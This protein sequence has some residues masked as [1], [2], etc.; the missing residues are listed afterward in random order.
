MTVIS[1][2]QLVSTTYCLQHIVTHTLSRHKFLLLGLDLAL[3]LCTV[4]KEERIDI[5]TPYTANL[6]KLRG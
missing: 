2:R 5:L 1:Y 6:T 3:L 4:H